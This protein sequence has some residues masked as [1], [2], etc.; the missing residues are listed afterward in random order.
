MKLS[1][2]AVLVRF[3]SFA[4]ALSAVAATSPCTD[5]WTILQTYNLFSAGDVWTS[6]DVE[7][8]TF[9]GGGLVSSNSA[10][11]GIH[12]SSTTAVTL[13]IAGDIVSGNAVQ[14]NK[15]S[16]AHQPGIISYLQ[17]PNVGVSGT[18]MALPQ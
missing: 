7:G 2:R 16:L 11:F 17:N 9:I 18:H 13:E 10:N 1:T 15:G 8:T 5:G 12:L 3:L 4:T 14:V 6:S